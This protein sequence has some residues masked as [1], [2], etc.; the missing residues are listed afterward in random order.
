[1]NLTYQ[2]KKE[3]INTL[4]ECCCED[5]NFLENRI[6]ELV[7]FKGEELYETYIGTLV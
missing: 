5:T 7:E 1:M 4:V 6:Y 3:L 2:E